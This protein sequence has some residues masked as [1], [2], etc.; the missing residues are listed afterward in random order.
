MALTA[1]DTT[2]LIDGVEYSNNTIDSITISYGRLHVWEQARS[3][4]AQ[5]SL[6]NPTNIN[7]PFDLNST[8]VIKTKN[9]TGVD[10]TL[11][12]GTINSFTGSVIANGAVGQVG[13]VQI[14][15]LGIFAKMS[16]TL[17]GESGYPKEFDDDRMTAIFTDAGVTIDVVDTPGVYEFTTYPK[18]TSNAYALA[19][20]YA[21]MAFGYIYETIDGK[22]GYANESRRT[23]EVATYGY[24]QFPK[25]YIFYNSVT[26]EKTSADVVNDIVLSYKNDAIVSESNSGSIATYGKISANISTELENGVEAGYQAMRWITLRAIP[27]TNLNAFNIELLNPNITNADIDVILQM[28][29]GKPIAILGLPNSIIHTTYEGFVEGWTWNISRTSISISINSTSSI[30][31]LTPT[32]WQDVDPALIWSAVDPA[33]QWYQYN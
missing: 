12:T 32:R 4:Y 29:V 16:R 18:E 25:N 20:K 9:A 28:Y 8:V 17:I 11:F 19:S 31:S 22:V 33:L 26:S 2:V 27:E 7:W 15:A 5:I 1:T 13:L 24:H 30:Y 6:F 3:S 14:Y 21:D 23:I 10:R